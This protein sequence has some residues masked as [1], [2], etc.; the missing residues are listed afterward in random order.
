MKDIEKFGWKK[1]TF[2]SY[3]YNQLKKLKDTYYVEH[4]DFSITEKSSLEEISKKFDEFIEILRLDKEKAKIREN[5]FPL[6]YL[7]NYPKVTKE[8][9]R[10]HGLNEQQTNKV[11]NI[12]VVDIT[13]IPTEYK[14][15]PLQEVKT[16]LESEY[17]CK[18]FLI[19]TS[20]QNMQGN[21]TI[22]SV[23]VYFI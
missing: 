7:D 18:V 23:P 17:G 16:A 6:K 4:L 8:I 10:I 3:Y 13:I 21:Q 19:D 11:G 1:P 22:S 2:E 9:R 12:L 5:E 15:K 20:R 14:G